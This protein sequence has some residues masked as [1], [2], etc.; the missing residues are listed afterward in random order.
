MHVDICDF[1]L[2]IFQNSIEADAGAV[3]ITFN[4]TDQVIECIVRDNGRGM[5]RE[6]LEKVQDP[7]YT[8][9]TK[10]SKREAGLGIPFL[11]QAVE[12]A[13]GEF[14]LDSVKGEGTT[15]RFTFS[16]S[17]IDCPPVGDIPRTFLAACSY[18]GSYELE[19]ERSCELCEE[20]HSYTIL[21][22]ELIEAVGDLEEVGSLILVRQFLQSQEDDLYRT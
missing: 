7:F 21:R 10:H 15:C 16:K 6:E 3:S 8:D 14:E 18:P 5:S 20:K 1:L 19:V 22:S 11:V 17:H 13:D 9:G 12:M 4:E 2:D